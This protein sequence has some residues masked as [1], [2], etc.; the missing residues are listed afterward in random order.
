MTPW[1]KILSA[2]GLGLFVAVVLLA[3]GAYLSP[4]MLIDLAN[5]RLC[6]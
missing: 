2:F 5:L 1:K 4:S 3:L 6:S